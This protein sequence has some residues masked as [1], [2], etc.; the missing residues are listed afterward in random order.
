MAPSLLQAGR[1]T[2]PGISRAVSRWVTC[3]LFP[4][5]K[6]R[7]AIV[8]WLLLVAGLGACW[9]VGHRWRGTLAYNDSPSVPVGWYVRVGGRE[10]VGH[11][12]Y[13]VFPAPEPT[14]PYLMDRFGGVAG[15]YLMK[16]VAAVPGD[17]VCTRG[18][19]VY[20]NGRP[21][22]RLTYQDSQGHD[23][24]VWRGGLT[25]GPNEIFVCCPEVPHSFDSRV[26]GPI[27]SS[28]V[29]GVY[30]PLWVAKTQTQ[31]KIESDQQD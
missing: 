2:S 12:G 29:L 30:R 6:R 8:R 16:P 9:V 23:V 25:L 1:A 28:Q 22:A 14:Y 18:D 7:R 31:E 3:F 11:G 27:Q 10:D 4:N 21:L 24:P 19:F 13:V 26:Y 5:T 15:W 20:V 17:Q